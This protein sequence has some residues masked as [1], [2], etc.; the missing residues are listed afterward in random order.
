VTPR[1]FV[2]AANRQ[3][4]K[5]LAAHHRPSGDALSNASPRR[6]DAVAAL[7]ALGWKREVATAAVDEALGHVARDAAIDVVL[8]EALRR[9][10]RSRG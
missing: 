8:R 9:C 2:P 4:G 3:P 5:G 1:R 10:P 7:R 6:Q